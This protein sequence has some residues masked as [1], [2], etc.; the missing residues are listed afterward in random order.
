MSR[1]KVTRE[2]QTPPFSMEI[3]Y[4]LVFIRQGSIIEMTKKMHRYTVVSV[5]GYEFQPNTWHP[6]PPGLSIKKTLVSP[7]KGPLVRAVCHAARMSGSEVRCFIDLIDTLIHT[8][9]LY[10]HSVCPK[11]LTLSYT[12]L[13]SPPLA[14]HFCF[15]LLFY[16]EYES[17]FKAQPLQPYRY[18]QTSD[19]NFQ[20]LQ[21]L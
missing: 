9:C 10:T 15:I 13:Y 6:F 7:E 1:K 8:L 2:T 17:L 5:W 19:S 20:I 18:T 12:W 3:I 16:W 21:C 14:L 4:W 11:S